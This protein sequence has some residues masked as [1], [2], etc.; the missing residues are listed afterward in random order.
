[1]QNNSIV[2][3]TGATG[4]Q[5]GAVVKHLLA[6]GFRVKALVRNADS[7]KAQILVNENLEIVTGD[8][9]EPES[10][11]H[12]LHNVDAIFCNLHFAEGVDKEI[13]QGISL[14]DLAKQHNIKHFIYS[15]VV[16]CDLNTGIPHWESKFKIENH[17]KSIGINYTILRP[18]SLLEN[19]LIPDVKKRVLKGKLV[20]PVKATLQQQFIAS[21]DIGRVSAIILSNTEKYKGRTIPLAGDQLDGLELAA[22]F[23]KVLDRKINFQQLPMLIVRLIMGKGLTKMFRWINKNEGLLLSDLTALHKEFPGM[24]T[25]EEWIKEKYN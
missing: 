3:V 21:D 6:N 15:S 13:R 19:L 8:L 20:L 16:G 22:A 18:A 5:G 7:P 9:N 1:M 25:V 17:I 11:Q 14:A 23:S 12:Y 2:F 24:V 10:Y 4:N